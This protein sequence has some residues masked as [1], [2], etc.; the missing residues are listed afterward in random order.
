MSF[1]LF[2]NFLCLMLPINLLSMLKTVSF[3]KKP[4]E[5]KLH[6]Y[7]KSDYRPHFLKNH[8]ITNAMIQYFFLEI[9]TRKRFISD[10]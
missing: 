2:M 4:F 9:N 8:S 3:H 5:S 10:R 1:S 6:K 7:Q